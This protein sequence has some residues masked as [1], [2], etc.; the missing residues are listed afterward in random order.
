[1]GGKNHGSKRNLKVNGV[2]ED[3][4]YVLG[5]VFKLTESR[6]IPLEIIVKKLDEEGCIIDWIS[7]YKEARYRALWKINT[8]VNKIDI[9]LFDLYGEEYR[10]EVVNRLKYYIVEVEPKE[11]E[12]CDDEE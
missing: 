1:M 8:I 5:G 4:K 7:F 10:D 6:G 12:K 11:Q 3:G 9:T 2:T